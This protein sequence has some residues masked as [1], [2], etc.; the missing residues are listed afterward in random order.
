[1][2]DAWAAYIN[3]AAQQISWVLPR[4]TADVC[5]VRM[6]TYADEC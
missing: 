4:T 6:L 2:D 5:A 1:M 3:Y